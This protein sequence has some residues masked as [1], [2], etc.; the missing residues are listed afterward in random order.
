[1]F[2]H[3]SKPES[4]MSIDSTHIYTYLINSCSLHEHCPLAVVQWFYGIMRLFSQ[5]ILQRA[6]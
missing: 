4:E 5:T 3:N 6:G 1:M 2:N